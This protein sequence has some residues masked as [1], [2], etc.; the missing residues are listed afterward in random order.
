M[1]SLHSLISLTGI[2]DHGILLESRLQIAKRLSC[3]FIYLFRLTKVSKKSICCKVTYILMLFEF[4]ILIMDNLY[5][6]KTK[7]TILAKAV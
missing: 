5:K 2:S 4:K 1:R 6:K 7:Q 3:D